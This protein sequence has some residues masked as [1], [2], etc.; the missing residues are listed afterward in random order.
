MTTN[1]TVTVDNKSYVDKNHAS[2]YIGNEVATQVKKSTHATI[3]E[4]ADKEE[5]QE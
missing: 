3:Q 5:D 2:F 4:N 1:G